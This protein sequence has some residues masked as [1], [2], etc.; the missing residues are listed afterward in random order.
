MDPVRPN[1]TIRTIASGC[2]DLARSNGGSNTW[3]SKPVEV[4][5]NICVSLVVKLASGTVTIILFVSKAA[6]V[7]ST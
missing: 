2:S 4:G 1:D 7:S 5:S 6:C 3:F